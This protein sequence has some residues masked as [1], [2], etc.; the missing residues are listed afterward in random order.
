MKIKIFIVTLVCLYLFPIAY[1]QQ[2]ETNY[3][4]AKWR[5]T[6]EEIK[7]TETEEFVQK[8]KS[9]ETGLDIL[10]YKCQAGGIDCLIAYY[11]AEN[12][13]VEGRYIFMGQHSNRNLYIDDYK[14]I[15]KGISE[16]YGK[17]KDDPSEWGMTIAVGHL[18]FESIWELPDTKINLQLQGDNYKISLAQ[19]YKSRIKAHEELVK[20]QQRKP[21]KQYGKERRINTS[22]Y[23][24]LAKTGRR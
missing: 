20:K 24:W 18:T 14:E 7:K 17:P 23:T 8:Q 5:M 9:K 22:I 15:K 12:Q 16:K 19:D 3:R 4:M 10:A 11:F 1:S 6:Q 21:K 13:L 2:E